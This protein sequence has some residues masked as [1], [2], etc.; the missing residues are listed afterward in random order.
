VSDTPERIWARYSKGTS[1]YNGERGLIVDNKLGPN[2]REYVPTDLVQS[3]ID[4]AVAAAY[5]DAAKLVE[6]FGIPR[7]EFDA[8]N[9]NPRPSLSQAIRARAA[10]KGK[11]NQ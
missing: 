4:A 10:L 1:P 9:G 6:T 2:L 3:H 5:E 8:H 7:D 11:G